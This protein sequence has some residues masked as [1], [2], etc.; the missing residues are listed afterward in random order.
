MLDLMGAESVFFPPASVN[1]A[2]VLPSKLFISPNP[3]VCVC[4]SECVYVCVCR[5]L[6]VFYGPFYARA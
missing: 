1:H 6:T 4:V 2:L 3:T 5:Y